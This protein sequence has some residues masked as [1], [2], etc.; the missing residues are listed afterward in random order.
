[1]KENLPWNIEV[2]KN[3]LNE[4]FDSNSES[5]LLSL[6][7]KNSFLLY[8]LYSRKFG[9]QPPFSEINFGTEL[10]CDFAWLNDNSAGPEW[11]LV[12][13]EKPR[14]ELFTRSGEPTQKLSHAIEQ[15]KSWRRYFD[16]NPHEKR[17][18]FG[19]ASTFR[20]V[21]VAGDTEIWSQPKPAQW[22]ADENKNSGIE[23]RSSAIF[24]RAIDHITKRPDD[25][26]SFA[27]YPVCKSHSE[28]SQ[29][30]QEYGYL[31]SWGRILG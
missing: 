16:K 10:R 2:V 20:F 19:A 21:V 27:E 3:E 5:K 25:F 31:D 6:I 23:V 12:E 14:M 17:R 30:C 4:I 18:I 1:M 28:L 7:N 15:V 9:I 8:E 22:R 13:V 29:F 24:H 26:W 11:V